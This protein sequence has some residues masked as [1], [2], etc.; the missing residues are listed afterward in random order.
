M[1]LWGLQASAHEFWI[2]PEAYV[3]PNGGQVQA[4]LRVGEEM[5]GAGYSFNPR[6]FERFELIQ[7]GQTVEV[8]GRLGDRPALDMTA[9]GEGL[10]VVVHETT[11]NRLTYTQMA[12][13]EK[14]ATHKDFDD[15]VG[16][17]RARGLPEDR[18]VERY[19][20]YAKSL[21]A[22]GD[23]AG[24]DVEVGMKTEILALANPYTDDLAEMP[25][26]VL[27]DGA[28]RADAQIELFEKAPDGSVTVTLHRTDAE[29]MGAVPVK[30]GHEY[31]VDAVAL[32]PLDEG[33]PTQTPVWWTVWA[34][35]TFMVPE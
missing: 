5:S 14:F 24:S 15:A 19:H 32:I 18:F 7:G 30:P 31:L 20:R 35:L 26:K 16:Q 11:A 12:K 33:D 3:I 13:F 21:I 1:S 25:V 27:L 23:G 34:A 10:L 2:S 9:P 6:T 8:E 29:G 22:V 4:E 17:H 28:P